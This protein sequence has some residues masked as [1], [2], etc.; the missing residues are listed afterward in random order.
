MLHATRHFGTTGAQASVARQFRA[1]RVQKLAREL[2]P[3][4]QQCLRKT[5]ATL[6]TQW[7]ANVYQDSCKTKCSILVDA[8]LIVAMT[9][10]QQ[11]Q[12]ASNGG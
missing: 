6:S 2:E 1:R 8:L 5:V 4:Q 3:E 10:Y 11:Y 9:Q 7:W 12:H